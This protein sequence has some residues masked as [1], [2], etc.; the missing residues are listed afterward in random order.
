MKKPRCRLRIDVKTLPPMRACM[1]PEGGPDGMP[2]DGEEE[3][4]REASKGLGKAGS[5]GEFARQALGS[6]RRK[7]RHAGEKRGLR[8]AHPVEA[9]D[10][11]NLR[12]CVAHGV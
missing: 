8:H 1:S 12:V 3:D 10:P 4:P 7:M 2:H 5:T 6:R 11:G 9:P